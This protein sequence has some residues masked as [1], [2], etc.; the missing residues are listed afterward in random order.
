MIDW[1]TCKIPCLHVPIQ[2]GQ[3]MKLTPDGEVEW[4]SVCRTQVAGAFDNTIS[5]RS[6]GSDGEGHATELH[7][8]GNPAK[9][10][11]GHN[12]IG[13][14][15]IPA[16]VDLAMQRVVLQL[17]DADLVTPFFQNAVDWAAIRSGRF[18]LDTFDV[19]YMYQL[20]SRSDVNAWLRAA[21][22]C[23]HTRHGR[24]RNDKGTV[25]WGKNSR[26]WS[27][28]GYGKAAEIEGKGKHK[29]PDHPR[30][31]PLRDWVQDKLRL[32]LRLRQLELRDL[33][34]KYAC[35]VPPA[36]VRELFSDYI[37]RIEMTEKMTLSDD[38]VLKL[39]RSLAG[40]Y[41]LWKAGNTPFD[42]LPK[43]TFYRHR[44]KLLEYGVD[45]SNPPPFA[46]GNNVV[47]LVRVLEAKPVE[48]PQWA[49]ERR[50]IA[51]A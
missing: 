8:S 43:P 18:E 28:K 51:V 34:I 37:G 6:L 44:K 22:Y 21:E 1:I 12:I 11:Q 46:A 4:A 20:P 33:G 30:F 19:N 41:H 25:Y 9:F 5:V 32:E 24:P 50:L 38:V 2:A 49:F 40:T 3:V 39:P 31:K 29:L 16:L 14:D 23:S 13:G 47:P 15:D 27:I 45:I 36:R 42:I 7:F 35:D 17:V 48:I 26:R 10:L